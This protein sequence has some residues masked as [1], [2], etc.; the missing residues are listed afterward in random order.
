MR[1]SYPEVKETK[2]LPNIIKSDEVARKMPFL[3]QNHKFITDKVSLLSNAQVAIPLDNQKASD[4]LV[5]AGQVL[6]ETKILSEQLLHQAQ[7]DA[8]RI[9]QKASQE[10][11]KEAEAIKQTAQ[12][13]G[14]AQGH[15]QG[16]QHGH[17]EGYR[18]GYQQGLE[19]G[20]AAARQEMA[21]KFNQS[22]K[23]AE[24]M[25]LQAEE[26]RNQIVLGADRQIIELA[27]AVASKVLAREIE[28]NPLIIL[29]IVTEALEKVRDQAQLVVRVNP[30]HYSLLL[31]AKN[32]LQRMIGG[33]QEITI[34]SDPSLGEADCLVETGNGTV[35]A[36]LE[37]Q[38]TALRQ[39]LEELV[40]Q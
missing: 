32:D 2:L 28:G 6:T 30:I 36:R 12:K 22:V 14:Y 34:L 29:P 1:L 15:E 20:T 16:T 24:K 5:E 40:S 10:A 4:P 11:S 27:L 26:A 18:D 8:G 35:D 7:T 3:I 13:D 33:Q 31:E 19:E 38:M 21:D 17:D 9:L 23:Q 25:L 37:T 39:R